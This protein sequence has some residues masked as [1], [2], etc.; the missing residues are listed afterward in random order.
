MEDR[1]QSEE[2]E[3][4]IIICCIINDNILCV[5]NCLL[6]RKEQRAACYQPIRAGLVTG[7]DQSRDA[8]TL[9]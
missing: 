4:F 7:P 5:F 2:A 1:Q 8:D 3:I 6:D 9:H